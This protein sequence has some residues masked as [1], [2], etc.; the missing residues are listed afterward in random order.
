MLENE[1]QQKEKLEG[2]IATLHSQLLQLSLTADEVK[3]IVIFHMKKLLFMTFMYQI[4]LSFFLFPNS[5]FKHFKSLYIFGRLDET[6][7]NMVQRKLLVLEI[8]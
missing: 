4:V 6:L 3:N 2:E 5:N 1:T 8:L 7:S